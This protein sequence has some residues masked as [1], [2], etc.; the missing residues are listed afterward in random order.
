MK[1]RIIQVTFGVERCFLTEDI[2]A[3]CD[4]RSTP[5]VH[6]ILCQVILIYRSM[7]KGLRETEDEEQICPVKTLNVEVDV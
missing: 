5:Q 7:V 4:I 2:Q 6:F 3:R 1:Q